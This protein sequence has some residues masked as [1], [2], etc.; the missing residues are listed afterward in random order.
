MTSTLRLYLALRK[1]FTGKFYLTLEWN[2]MPLYWIAAGLIGGVLLV[3][4]VCFCLAPYSINSPK[5]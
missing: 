1:T 5:I 2:Y 4:A 3:V